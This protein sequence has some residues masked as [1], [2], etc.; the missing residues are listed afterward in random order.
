MT[1][2][3]EDIDVLENLI[4]TMNEG[5]SDEKR[6]ALYSVQRLIDKKKAIIA[7]FEAEHGQEETR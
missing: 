6:M 1:D 7:D 3:F 5:A 2:L 4:I